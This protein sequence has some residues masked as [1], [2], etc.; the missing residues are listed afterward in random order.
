MKGMRVGPSGCAALHLLAC[1]PRMPTG[2]VARLL[3]MR[4]TRSAAQLLLRLRTAGLARYE[5]AKPGPV[6]GARGV[7][8][9]TLTAAGHELVDRR[10]LAPSEE[11]GGLM[12]YGRPARRP[13]TERQRDTPMLVVAYRLLGHV[14]RE[15]DWPVRVAAWEHP[16]IRTLAHAEIGRERHVRLPAAAVLVQ[17][18]LEGTQPRG[19]LLLPDVG[20][21]P[22]ASY[23]PVLHRL[24]ALRLAANVSQPD[25]PFLVVGVAVAVGLAARVAAWQTL[26]QQVARQAGERPLRA[27]VFAWPDGMAVAGN[28]ERALGDQADQVLGLVARHPLLE[29]QQLAVLLDVSEARAGQLVRRLTAVGWIRSFKAADVPPE[30]LGPRP[31]RPRRLSLVE[32]TPTGRREV[33]RR[34]LLPASVAARHHGLLGND[35]STRQFSRHFAHTLGANA[36]V[37]AFILTA[38]RIAQR[39][40]DEALE[41]WRSAAACAHGRFRPDG[42]G[43]Y[44]RE[45]ARFGFFLEFDRGTE[46]ARE[47]AAKLDAYCRYRES[48]A[49]KR[50]YAGFPTLLV[51]TTSGAAE[52]RFA[53]QAHLVQQRHGGS[54]LS[55]FLTTTSHIDACPEGVLGPIWRSAADPWAA[56]PVRICWLP[57]LRGQQRLDSAGAD[58]RQVPTGR[59]L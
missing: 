12:P 54:P 52:A 2:V 35:A 24:I 11:A 56:E 10:G 31:G 32:L 49:A 58:Y 9:W 37:V 21:L 25:E 15:M 40:G 6:V 39:S 14:V 48:P 22:V 23:Q 38:R 30:A 16:W 4:H 19:L 57:R 46:K 42:Y 47:Y 43:C 8:L 5:T 18:N 45:G 55:I 17:D 13:D 1:C 36:V 7:R 20:T 3:R 34:L 53:S 41:E 26:L 59:T 29:R 28:Q 27:R 50:A 33:A 51:V 44:R